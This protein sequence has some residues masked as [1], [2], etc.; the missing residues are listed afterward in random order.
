MALI[1]ESL[2]FDILLFFVAIITTIYLLLK[3]NYSYWERNGFKTLPNY[4]Y[5]LGHLKSGSIHVVNKGLYKASTDGFNGIYAFLR[6]MLLVRDP[7]LIRS[8]LIKDFAHFTDRTQYCNK[9][10]DPLSGHLAFLPGPEWKDI[11]GKLTPA[12]TSGKLKGM[13][14]TLLDCGF[15]LQNYLENLADKGE[16]LN[17]SEISA[18]HATNVIASV[19]FGID[20]DTIADPNNDFRK[21]GRKIFRKKISNFMRRLLVLVAPNLMKFLHIK[22]VESDIEKFIITVVKENLEYRE[23]NN[24]SRKDFF[25]LLIQVNIWNDF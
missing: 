12:F 1:T 20:I 9:K 15:K 7:E 18:S 21:Y 23:K 5:F 10:N 24:V 19:A 17:V 25:Q 14:P 11:R 3:R 4:T 6:P 13:F 16:L 2:K 8:I 22:Y